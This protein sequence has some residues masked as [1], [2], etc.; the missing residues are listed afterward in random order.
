MTTTKGSSYAP[1]VA[2]ALALVLLSFS[3]WWS[4]RKASS[5]EMPSPSKP[6]LY[7]LADATLPMDRSFLLGCKLARSLASEQSRPYLTVIDSGRELLAADLSLVPPLEEAYFLGPNTSTKTIDLLDVL[8][9]LTAQ[10][11]GRRPQW[12][13]ITGGA[14][15]S[16]ETRG[17]RL[18]TPGRLGNDYPAAFLDQVWFTAP[19]NRTIADDLA[20][21]IQEGR[22]NKVVIITQTRGSRSGNDNL[23]YTE[24]LGFHLKAKLCK[25]SRPQC[26][27][28][29]VTQFDENTTSVL[30][31]DGGPDVIVPITDRVVAQRLIPKLAGTTARIVAPDSWNVETIW[32]RLSH[33]GLN[34]VTAALSLSK[35]P[36]YQ[37]RGR[38]C[39]IYHGD[40]GNE[41]L[42]AIESFERVDV[43][44]V[45]VARGFDVYRSW[46]T[47]VRHESDFEAFDGTKQSLALPRPGIGRVDLWKGQSQMHTKPP[48]VERLRYCGDRK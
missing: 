36:E 20:R 8:V 29:D 5:A 12:R 9:N 34:H 42:P 41:A 26:E 35:T 47:I 39:E 45:A 21:A 28:I 31:T 38:L 4:S 27:F 16:V 3:A 14:T 24:Q 44:I 22:P 13:F 37:L 23:V 43:D 30:Q 11:K 46:Q 2:L 10:G 17:E 7:V 6:T 40:V 1:E 19:D 25:A 18:V 33:Y 32:N 48:E 15:L